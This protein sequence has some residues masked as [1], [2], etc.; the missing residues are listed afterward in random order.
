M[1][2]V[3]HNSQFLPYLLDPTQESLKKGNFEC[4][5][6]VYTGDLEDAY[7]LTQ[8]LEEAWHLNTNVAANKRSCRSTSVGDLLKKD[9]QFY[10][11]ESCGFK[12]LSQGEVKELTILTH[13]FVP[14]KDKEAL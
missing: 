1:I 11:V 6:K 3:F 9:D 8:N 4:V 13:D 2:E 5:G 7:K 10:V 12:L 14:V